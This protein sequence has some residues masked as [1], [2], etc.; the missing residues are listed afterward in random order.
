MP[1][2]STHLLTEY[3]TAANAAANETQTL[4]SAIER[5]TEMVEAEVGAVVREGRVR[6]AYGF[7]PSSARPPCMPCVN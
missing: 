1:S 5:A 3:F 6:A 4:N 7:G 2:W